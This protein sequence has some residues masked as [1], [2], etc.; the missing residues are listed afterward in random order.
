MFGFLTP[1]RHAD[2]G[3]LTDVAAADKFWQLLPR[4]DPLAAQEALSEALSDLVERRNVGREQ[5]RALLALDQR[6]RSLGRAL[7]V[8]F[9]TRN[10]QA[11]PLEKRYWRSAVSMCE[12]FALA[13]EHFL[14]QI[15]YDPNPRIWREH[16]TMVPLRLFKHRQVELLL[17]PLL[18][19]A[20]APAAWAEL[21]AA[22]RF[23]AAK[24]LL[25]QPIMI[26]RKGEE[27]G[28]ESTLEREYIHA[29]LLDLMNGGQFSPYDAFWLSRW[30]PRWARAL[31]LQSA[32]VGADRQADHFVV[33]LDGGEGLKRGSAAVLGEAL[34][35][36][37]A[38]LLA[39]ID[40]EIELLHDADHPGSVPSTFGRAR[41]TKL[42]RKVAGSFTPRPVRV[43]RRGERKPAAA[44]VKAIVG[45]IPILRMLRHEERK[46]LAAMPTAVPEVEEITITADG[47][48]TQTAAAASDGSKGPPE[49][50]SVF[51]FGVQHHVWQLKDRS[52][53]GCRLRAP[54]GD[55]HRLPPG[56]LAAIRDDETMRWS[57]VVVRRRKTRIGDRVDIGVEYIG[58]NPRGVTLATGGRPPAASEGE[59]HGK[60]SLIT[61]LYLR[62]SAKQPVM[63]FKTLIMA[64]DALPGDQGLT[65][66]STAAEYA[67]RLK[68]PIEEQ[69][70]FVWLPY[71]VV[72]RR[73][74]D[75][76]AQDE[77]A[78]RVPPFRQAAGAP[79]FAVD[80]TTTT[81]WLASRAARRAGGAA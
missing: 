48:Y 57:L 32:P 74:S 68:E 9:A 5:L 29:L 72:D 7:F 79:S 63:P 37:P 27:Q 58:Q 21:H 25:H 13:Y 73:E 34:A 80:D 47:G 64:V 23:A 76:A 17:R 12:A 45:L 31:S 61:A 42:L 66:R 18:N 54:I 52:A 71:E 1:D 40:A 75:R 35:L 16:G 33:E 22:Y 19:T 26:T 62:E 46:R 69:D 50:P 77:T 44:T 38:P 43:N 55:A 49:P 59:P 65:L 41:Q 30:V 14:R 8:N 4:N 81:E 11:R 78:G 15:R 70:D 10:A 2:A 24:G 56:T 36:D 20:M 3:P 51:E 60:R 53:S 6:A 28:V 67:I 39:L